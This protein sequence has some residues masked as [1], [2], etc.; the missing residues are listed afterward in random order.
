MAKRIPLPT[1]NDGVTLA[2]ARGTRPKCRLIGGPSAG[3]TCS[4]SGCL[5]QTASADAKTDGIR[6]PS[7]TTLISP[8]VVETM[9][10]SQE[11]HIQDGAFIAW[12]I[13][14]AAV[15]GGVVLYEV[16]TDD[17]KPASPTTP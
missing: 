9:L 7:G 14:L 8:A 16:I 17:D 6:V 12:W 4:G 5:G 1:N 3:A 15:A 13:P 10:V 11:G 2:V